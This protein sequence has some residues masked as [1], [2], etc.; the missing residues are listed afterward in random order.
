ML[1]QYFDALIKTKNQNEGLVAFTTVA[2]PIP[3]SKDIQEL[4]GS[5][6]DSDLE[7]TQEN[8][9]NRL[10]FLLGEKKQIF[11]QKDLISETEID[12]TVLID[13]HHEEAEKLIKKEAEFFLEKEQSSFAEPGFTELEKPLSK[14]LLGFLYDDRYSDKIQKHPGLRALKN[15]LESNIVER[16][17]IVCKSN[18][19]KI[20][21]PMTVV[22]YVI[23]T[24]SDI[25]KLYA[26]GRKYNNSKTEANLK[27][28]EQA[29]EGLKNPNNFNK[30]KNE[31]NASFK[32]VK[33]NF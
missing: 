28:L 14:A 9:L 17:L 1:A 25:K 13:S 2:L 29:I 19:I 31:F 18:E 32:S 24:D 16:F 5:D 10:I 8:F 22:N 30:N 3:T 23:D 6:F 33:K 27:N 11:K 21:D 20:Y 7:K 15:N 26:L 4:L 12:K